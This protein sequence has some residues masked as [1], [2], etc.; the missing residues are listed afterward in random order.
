MFYY[1]VVI[2]QKNKEYLGSGGGV[3]RAFPIVGAYD[4]GRVCENVQLGSDELPKS[5]S[6]SGPELRYIPLLSHTP[7]LL[8]SP[9]HPS[10]LHRITSINY[11]TTASLVGQR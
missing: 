7:L 8:F 3:L 2:G 11:F 1:V 9:L 5:S 4:N 6:C 10:T